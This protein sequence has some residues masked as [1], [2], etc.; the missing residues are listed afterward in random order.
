MHTT[1][2]V[3]HHLLM[4]TGWEGAPYP[5]KCHINL[6]Q[7]SRNLDLT[8]ANTPIRDR[9]FA[10]RVSQVA[11]ISGGRAELRGDT[12]RFQGPTHTRV[13]KQEG[14]S[15]ALLA[16]VLHPRACTWQDG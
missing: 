3:P 13:P 12:S 6:D 14:T 9:R 8:G 7:D 11:V 4:G 2:R 5:W 1:L 16:Q 10:P 15:P